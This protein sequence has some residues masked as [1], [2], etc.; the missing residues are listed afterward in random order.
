MTD[1]NHGH[2]SA[3]HAA[4]LGLC[5]LEIESRFLERVDRIQGREV[6]FNDESIL[7]RLERIRCYALDVLHGAGEGRRALAAAV[8]NVRDSQ[9]CNFT[10]P[11]LDRL[12]RYR[13]DV[14]RAIETGL[15][16]LV[17]GLL[18][19]FASWRRQVIFRTA[20]GTPR[21]GRTDV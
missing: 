9:S 16:D 2:V 4:S 15:C 17:D 10:L 3:I 21:S 6:A 19:V 20:L 8:A 1:R 13:F 18:G 7:L 12:E 11:R 5:E 14:R